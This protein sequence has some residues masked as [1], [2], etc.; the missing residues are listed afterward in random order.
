MS[1]TATRPLSCKGQLWNV[2]NLLT[3]WQAACTALETKILRPDQPQPT[4]G[5]EHRVKVLRG[6]GGPHPGVLDSIHLAASF[7]S[8]SLLL[9]PASLEQHFLLMVGG[10]A[11]GKNEG[12]VERGIFADGILCF[13]PDL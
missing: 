5:R 3:F 8:I 4:P 6:Q 13:C 7:L 10:E 2:R 1:L 12:L 9:L 11:F